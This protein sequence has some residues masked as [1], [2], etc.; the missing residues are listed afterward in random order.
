M[1]AQRTRSQ[2]RILNL[3]KTMNRAVSAQDIY[4][5]LRNRSQSMGLATVY[6]SLE[7]LKLDGVVQVRTLASGE[8]LYSSVQQDKHHLTCLQCGDSIPI[9]QCPVH[10][11]ESQLQ[12]SHSFKIFYHTLEF[13]GLCDRC[14]VA[15]VASD[16]LD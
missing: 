3:L 16:A 9:N 4:V 14:C 12:Q 7:A 5:E 15:Q 8:S 11:L 2:E 1:K 6:R 10:E 13:F